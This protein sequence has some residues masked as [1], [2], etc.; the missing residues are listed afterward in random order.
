MLGNVLVLEREAGPLDELAVKLKD[1][2]FQVR[3][4]RSPEGLLAAVKS[5]MPHLLIAE[6]DF[7]GMNGSILADRLQDAGTIPLMLVLSTAGEET[8]TFMRRHPVII[9]VYYLPLNLEKMV[10]RVRRFF[11]L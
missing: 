10:E 8:Q 4:E 9:G 3:T 2:G 11:R 7:A 1:D 5:E 6:G